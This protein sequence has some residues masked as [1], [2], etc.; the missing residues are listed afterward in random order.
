MNALAA[1]VDEHTLEDEDTILKAREHVI[2][3]RVMREYAN[4][5]MAESQEDKATNATWAETRDTLV[6]DYCQN[7]E[8]PFFGSS[9]P[10]ESYYMSPRGVYCFGVS[11]VGVANHV[12]QAYIYLEGEGRKGGNNVASLLLKYLQ[13]RGWIDQTKGAR[14]EL[15]LILDNCGGQ[16]KNRMVL[17]MATLLVTI[18]T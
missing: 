1:T 9:Q 12:L 18:R 16:N 3:A 2:A 15:T 7:M 13:D 14:A 8:L 4:K 11:N 6:G 10:G 17:R 5:K